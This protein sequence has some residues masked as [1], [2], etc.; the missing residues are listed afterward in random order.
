M[1]LSGANKRLYD[2]LVKARAAVADL[3]DQDEA[4]GP[5]FEKLDREVKALETANI[6]DPIE[7]A[8]AK[9]AAQM[10]SR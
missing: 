7:R 3:Y 6:S 1:K 4:F 5:F 10:A 8:R 2:R 9:L